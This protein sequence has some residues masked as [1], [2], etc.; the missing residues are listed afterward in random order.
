VQDGNDAPQQDVLPQNR[1]Q[2]QQYRIF[3]GLWPDLSQALEQAIHVVKPVFELLVGE[4]E[5]Q[6]FFAVEVAEQSALGEVGLRGDLGHTDLAEWAAKEEVRCG[7]EHLLP[8]RILL[9]WAPRSFR[10]HGIGVFA[11]PTAIDRR[12]SIGNVNDRWSIGKVNRRPIA[13]RGGR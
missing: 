3:A 1:G 2:S 7:I 4:G 5:K 9:L 12:S 6:R 13:A 11:L 10:C 8:P